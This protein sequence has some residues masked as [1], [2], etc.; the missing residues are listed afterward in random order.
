MGRPSLPLGTP[1][2]VRTWKEA[3]GQYTSRCLFRDFDGVARPLERS[4]DTKAGSQRALAEAIRDRGQRPK[5]DAELTSDTKV[6]VLAEVWW[7][8]FLTLDRSPGTQRNYRDRLDKQV[9][10]GIGSLY[11]RELSIGRAERFLRSIEQHHGASLTKTTRTVLSDMCAY[12]ARHDALDRNPVGETSAITVAPK[13]RPQA[14][15]LSEARQLRAYVSYDPDSI[16]HDVPDLVSIMLASGLRIGEAL[17]LQWEAVELEAGTIEV[18]GTVVRVK[19]KGLV[20]KPA[21]KTPAG[22][23]KLILPSWGTALLANRSV[24]SRR[25]RVSDAYKR[26]DYNLVFPSEVNGLRDP[27]NMQHRL[28]TAFTF[29]GRPDVTSH[30][31]RKTVSTAMHQASL[32]MSNISDQLGHAHVSYTDAAQVTKDVYLAR[33]VIDTGAAGVLEALAA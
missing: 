14:L 32:P 31:L 13:N 6:S 15:S 17:A 4:R 30:W 5:G 33:G 19:G 8:Y 29:A 3:N 23:R 7:A 24:T 12:A 21:P 16:R 2:K 20:I 1:G 18:R 25:F 22:F 28:K 27:N 10:P 26:T 9:I 11:L